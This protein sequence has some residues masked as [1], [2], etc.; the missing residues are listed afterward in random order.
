V[1]DGDAAPLPIKT[2]KC[3]DTEAVFGLRRVARF[4]NIERAALRKL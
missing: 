1:Q 3:A 2:F 4:V